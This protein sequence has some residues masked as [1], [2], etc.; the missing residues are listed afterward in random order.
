MGYG[1]YTHPP[2]TRDLN[3]EPTEWEEFQ[4][5]DDAEI[6]IEFVVQKSFSLVGNQSPPKI[7]KNY[8]SQRPPKYSFM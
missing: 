6:E 1:L 2:L 7:D 8:L 4:E 3:S 5:L